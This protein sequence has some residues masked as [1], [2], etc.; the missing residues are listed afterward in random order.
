[1]GRREGPDPPDPLPIL[2]LLRPVLRCGIGGTNSYDCPIP[3]LA[4]KCL[5]TE[6]VTGYDYGTE[7]VTGYDYDGYDYD[8]T[9]GP[10]NGP[11]LECVVATPPSSPPSSPPSAKKPCKKLKK[12]ADKQK[13]KWKRKEEKWEKK[14]SA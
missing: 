13:A 12:S 5:G 6:N 7:G 8:G 2:S 1:M 10:G 3:A 9:D 14:C 11:W 4:D